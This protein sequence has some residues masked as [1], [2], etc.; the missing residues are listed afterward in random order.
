MARERFP[1]E[2]RHAITLELTPA[3]R[4]LI[5]PFI[6]K[7]FG[8]DA[9]PIT[10][11]SSLE[12]LLVWLLEGADK[13]QRQ[14][15][16]DWF[17]ITAIKVCDQCGKF[18]TKGYFVEDWLFFCSEDCLHKRY[19]TAQYDALYEADLAYWTDW[20]ETHNLKWALV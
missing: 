14:D 16:I 5:K 4:S 18:M 8:Y 3:R 11:E 10:N 12:G 15:F 7:E 9:E 17:G 19:Y 2:L 20:N 1:Y 6:K 13:I